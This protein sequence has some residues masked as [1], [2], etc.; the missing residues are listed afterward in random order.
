MGHD[1]WPD[2][3]AYFAVRLFHVPFLGAE[4]TLP[5]FLI[6][7]FL[8]TVGVLAIFR[9]CF[10]QFV[11]GLHH[12]VHWLAFATDNRRVAISH[13]DKFEEEES[14]RC[15]SASVTSHRAK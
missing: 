12:F 14:L 9:G 1:S 6:P 11:H 2:F 4:F 13:L 3:V 5:A 7:C 8:A 15:G 10:T